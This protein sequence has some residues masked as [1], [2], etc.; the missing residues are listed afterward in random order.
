MNFLSR[1]TATEILWMLF[2]LPLALILGAYTVPLAVLLVL[3]AD[4]MSAPWWAYAFIAAY[5]YATL[6]FHDWREGTDENPG[7]TA[8]NSHPPLNG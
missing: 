8:R 7:Q 3:L 5:L 4:Y 1:R 2:T 6:R